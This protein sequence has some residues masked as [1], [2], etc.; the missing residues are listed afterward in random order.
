MQRLALMLCRSDGDFPRNR[1]DGAYPRRVVLGE[2]VGQRHTV[3]LGDVLRRCVRVA[4]DRIDPR[5][6]EHVEGVVAASA[7]LLRHSRDASA[8]A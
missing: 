4:D 2:A 1:P 5:G 3:A 6:V 8:F 7:R